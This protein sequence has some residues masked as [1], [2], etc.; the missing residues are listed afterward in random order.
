M[1]APAACRVRAT[2][3]PTRRAPP[4]INTT[5]FL[6]TEFSILGLMP[7]N[8][9]PSSRERELEPHDAALTHEMR[10]RAELMAQIA[11]GGGYLSFEKFMEFALYAPGLG[12]YSGGARKF[13]PDGDFITAPEVSALFGACVAVQ[14]AEVCER[15][16]APVLLEIGAGTGRLSLDILTRLESLGA[17]PAS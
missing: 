6:S 7:P 9:T 1:F 13:G 12:Y 15:M 17:S 4:V 3:A 5:W 8:D 10:V 2:S 11:A 16:Q 14:C